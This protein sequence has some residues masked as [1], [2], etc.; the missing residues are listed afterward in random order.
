MFVTLE[1]I[2]KIRNH[3]VKSRVSSPSFIVSEKILGFILSL[4]IVVE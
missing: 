4:I 1:T 3:N 2:K